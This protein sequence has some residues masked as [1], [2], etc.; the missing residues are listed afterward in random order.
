LHPTHAA[1]LLFFF[2]LS[3]FFK[4]KSAFLGDFSL[5]RVIFGRKIVQFTIFKPHLSISELVFNFF[6]VILQYQKRNVSVA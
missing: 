4:E 6:A 3:I 1:K 5:K 2:Q